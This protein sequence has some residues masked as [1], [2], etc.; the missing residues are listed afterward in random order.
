MASSFV[1]NPF[2]ELGLPNNASRE[3]CKKAYK[4]LMRQHHPDLGRSEEDIL[5]RGEKCKR[6]NEAFR[7]IEN[8]YK[9]KERRVSQSF[10]HVDLFNFSAI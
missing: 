1:A 2:E 9:I 4:K 8:G 3:D 10:T 6:L 7:L 5:R